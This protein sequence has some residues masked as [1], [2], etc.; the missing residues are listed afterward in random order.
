MILSTTLA[1]LY[2]ANA[3]LEKGTAPYYYPPKSESHYEAALW[4]DVF[5]AAQQSLGLPI[6]TI[7]ATVPL[8]DY[9]CFPN[10]GYPLSVARPLVGIELW[11]LGLFLFL[12]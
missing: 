9:G 8:D 4:N 12:H 3:L 7:R 10:G 11:T 2:Y 1:T 6:G 5:V